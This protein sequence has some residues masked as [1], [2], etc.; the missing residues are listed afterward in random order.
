MPVPAGV[1]HSCLSKA[2]E[3]WRWAVA[4]TAWA[5]PWSRQHLSLLQNYP[6]A[7]A[8]VLSTSVHPKAVFLLQK[9]D[10]LWPF[11]PDSSAYYPSSDKGW[12]HWSFQSDSLSH[13]YRLS[14]S[15][16]TNGGRDFDVFNPT[17][18]FGAKGENFNCQA[19]RIPSVLSTLCVS[20]AKPWA[21]L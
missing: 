5:P 3:M 14:A 12:R 20:A 10:S 21:S 4:F 16:H 6:P 13:D 15:C 2:Q 19:S 8:W 7:F 9:L 17:V 18:G 1:V 11:P